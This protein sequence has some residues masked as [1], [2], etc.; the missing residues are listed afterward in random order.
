VMRRQALYQRTLRSLRTVW[1][2]SGWTQGLRILSTRLGRVGG[3][4]VTF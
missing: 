1:K 3:E 2:T 4:K